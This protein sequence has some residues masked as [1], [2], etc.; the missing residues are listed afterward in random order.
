VT[1]LLELLPPAVGMLSTYWL[2]LELPG[3]MKYFGGVEAS[4]LAGSVSATSAATIVALM[5]PITFGRRKS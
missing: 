4:A 1:L 2:P 3:G 5:P